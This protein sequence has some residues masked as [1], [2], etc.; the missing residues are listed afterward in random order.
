MAIVEAR[1]AKGTHLNDGVAKI[2]RRGYA[3][4]TGLMPYRLN[5][6]SL[7]PKGI[8]YD[9]ELLSA[10]SQVVPRAGAII[11]VKFETKAGHAFVMQARRADGSYVPFGAQVVDEHGIEIG[12]VGQEGRALVRVA[13][14]TRGRLTAIWSVGKCDVDWNESSATTGPGGMSMIQGVC[15]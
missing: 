2:D 9:V 8:S 3:V 7:D 15:R 13:D 4:A 1:G 14:T 11:P 12:F 10:A 6:V 5:T